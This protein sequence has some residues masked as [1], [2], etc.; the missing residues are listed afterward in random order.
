M[1]EKKI[2]K[3]LQ[4]AIT[5]LGSGDKKRMDQGIGVISSK[6]HVG[7][8]K[9][10]IDLLINSKDPYLHKRIGELLSNIQD[11]HA[12]EIIMDFVRNEKYKDV[13]TEILNSIWCSKLDYSA[14]IADFVAIAVEG[15]LIQSVECLT[16]IEN[17]TGPFNESDLLEAQL[18][19]QEYHSNRKEGSDQKNQIISDIAL[20][21]KDQNEGVDADL[22]IE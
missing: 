18:F 22:L 17:M 12:C 7:V 16:A 9:P 3:S 21:I 13:R 1:A 11:K 6:G 4:S 8:I 14:Y 5:D 15:D 20:F 2:S 10:L 19:L